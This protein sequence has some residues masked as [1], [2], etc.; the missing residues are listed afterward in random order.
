MGKVDERSKNWKSCRTF[1]QN[2]YENYIQSPIGLVPK[3]GNKTRLIFHLS[4]NFSDNLEEDGS[5]NYFTPKEKCSVHYNDLDQAVK[6]ILKVIEIT[7]TK[8]VVFSK[9]DLSNAFRV[10]PLNCRSHAWLI[11]KAVDPVSGET[12]YFIDKC[13]P[14]GA[15][16]S[17]AHFQRVSNALRVL[18]EHRTLTFQLVTNYLDDF[19][20]VEITIIACNA[21]T[22]QFLQLCEELGFLVSMEKTEWACEILVFLGVLLN[23]KSLTLAIPEE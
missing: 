21:I 14:F 11:M 18:I 17:C 7:G 4:Y 12:V 20:F 9:S 6:A 15:S 1:Q 8:T 3:A 16:I 22:E 19:L 10:L 23:G 2:P 5:L 13:L